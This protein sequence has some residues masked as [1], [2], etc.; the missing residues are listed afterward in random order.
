M[1]KILLLLFLPLV[2][3]AQISPEFI[4]L[5]PVYAKTVIFNFTGADQQWIVPDGVNSVFIDVFGAQGGSAPTT[6]AGGLG[7][8]VRATLVV[9]PGETLLLKVGGQPTSRI[10]VYGDGGA[11]GQH[12]SVSSRSGMAG[13]GL[14]G[15]YRTSISI[16]NAIL[17][18]G[19]GGGAANNRTGG[20]GGGLVGLV[21]SDDNVRG[22]KGGTQTAGGALGTFI[23]TNF[24]APTIGVQG[25]GG[26][27]G[28]ISVGS[29]TA[30]GG[31]GA[32]FFG[33]A[34]GYGGGNFYGAGGG[35]SSWAHP[36]CIQPSTFSNFNSGHGKI[37]IY[38]N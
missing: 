31:G 23:D 11:G 32:G 3:S 7:G 17:I 36:S 28:S 12:T 34:G 22:G 15:V 14:S 16:T 5:K 37:V 35:G 6:G 29:H 26:Q 20:A 21:S 18:A 4:N 30:G 38:Y 19:G 8:K 24:I 1:K 2:L 25:S 10:P 9:T 33:G 13:G 27:G